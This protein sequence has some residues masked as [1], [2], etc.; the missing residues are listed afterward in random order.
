MSQ[1]SEESI[2]VKES[3]LRVQLFKLPFDFLAVGLANFAGGLRQDERFEFFGYDLVD[4][5]ELRLGDL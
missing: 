1:H 2:L 4:L 3:T 5:L